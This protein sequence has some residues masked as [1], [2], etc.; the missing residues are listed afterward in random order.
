MTFWG[1]AHNNRTTTHHHHTQK[2]QKMNKML[3]TPRIAIVDGQLLAYIPFNKNNG[4][5]IYPKSW[6]EYN[7][8]VIR[9]PYWALY[10]F[11]DHLSTKR[12]ERLLN[13]LTEVAA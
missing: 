9:E 11:A 2:E 12:G 10:D 6:E 8:F 7:R 3:K 5:T 13:A 4:I 1:G